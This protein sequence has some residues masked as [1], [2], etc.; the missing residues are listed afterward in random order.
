[1]ESV[2]HLEFKDCQVNMSNSKKQIHVPM[3]C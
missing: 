1:M 3:N 2:K